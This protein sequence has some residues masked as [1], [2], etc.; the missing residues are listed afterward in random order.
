MK[1]KAHSCITSASNQNRP[2]AVQSSASKPATPTASLTVSQS[3]DLKSQSDSEVELAKKSANEEPVS[4]EQ[5]PEDD[6]EKQE[7]VSNT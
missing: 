3:P 6:Q 5:D 1:P 4:E 2:E 7:V